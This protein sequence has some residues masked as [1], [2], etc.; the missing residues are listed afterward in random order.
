MASRFRKAFIPTLLS[1]GETALADCK[2]VMCLPL[3]K[4]CGEIGKGPA[5]SKNDG[6]RLWPGVLQGQV[7]R[8]ELVKFV[9]RELRD[10]SFLQTQTWIMGPNGS[11]QHQMIHQEAA[12]TKH[13]FTGSDLK[14]FSLIEQCST[15]RGY[16]ETVASPLFTLWTTWLD[17]DRADP[18][19][20]ADLALSRKLIQMTLSTQFVT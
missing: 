10:M 11:W 16:A 5:G 7:E 3:Q 14:S 13:Y 15:K 1:T 17:I 2:P 4:G 9:E 8:A 19:S 12:V 18:D 6:Q 20:A